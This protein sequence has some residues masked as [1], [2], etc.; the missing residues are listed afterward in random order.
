MESFKGL[1]MEGSSVVKL[2]LLFCFLLM[3]L[4]VIVQSSRSVKLISNLQVR[5]GTQPGQKVVLKRKGENLL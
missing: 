1:A 3:Y 4:L 5:P 2:L